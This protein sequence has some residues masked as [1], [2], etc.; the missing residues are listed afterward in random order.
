MTRSRHGREAACIR[1]PRSI[2]IPT[3]IKAAEKLRRNPD[4]LEI[5][6]IASRRSRRGDVGEQRNAPWNIHAVAPPVPQRQH[7]APEG[8]GIRIVSLAQRV[9]KSIRLKFFE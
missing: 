7:Y 8:S 4:C 6:Q 5:G 1:S 9:Q 3:F 2:Q